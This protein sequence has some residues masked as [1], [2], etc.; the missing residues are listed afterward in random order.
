[1]NREQAFDPVREPIEPNLC[2]EEESALDSSAYKGPVVRPMEQVV[3]SMNR[4]FSPQEEPIVRPIRGS[5]CA[6]A[7]ETAAG[8]PLIEE[9]EA[10]HPP[11]T[12]GEVGAKA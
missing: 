11:R 5:N 4:W 6:R 7:V 1:M 10:Y 9:T 12:S 2:V 3:Q 8:E